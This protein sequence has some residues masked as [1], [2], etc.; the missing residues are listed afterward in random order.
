MT[1]SCK[2]FQVLFRVIKREKMLK[3]SRNAILNDS[4]SR[5]SKL[6]SIKQS[7]YIGNKKI[8]AQ[9]VDEASLN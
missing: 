5:S 6:K 9:C 2:T 3:M 1:N 4:P 7:K 8:G